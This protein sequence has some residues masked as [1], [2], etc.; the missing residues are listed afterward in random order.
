MSE[1]FK[2]VIVIPC[3]RHAELLLG[4]IDSI[5]KYKTP[6][7]IV[8][9]GNESSQA[10][11]LQEIAKKDLVKLVVGKVNGGKGEALRLGAMKALELGYTHILQIDADGQHDVTAIPNFLA[12]AQSFPNKLICGQPEYENVPLGR[13]LSRFITHFWVCV[14]LGSLKII[15]SLCGFRVY[16]LASFTE[17]ISKRSIGKRMAFDIDILVRMY[18]YGVDIQCLKVRVCYPANGISNFKPL[19]DNL[20]ISWMHTKLCFEKIIYFWPIHKRRYL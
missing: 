19:R 14:E 15:D 11:I 5:L 7:I 16:P 8:D 17:I 9:D 2:P 13:Y 10:Q 1:I 18:W 3:Y 12:L 4:C 20:N 6:V